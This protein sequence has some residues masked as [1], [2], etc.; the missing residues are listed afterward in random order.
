M[1]GSIRKRGKSYT[2]T[3]DIGRHADG[4]RRQHTETFRTRR[5]ADAALANLLKQAQN[6]SYIKP[7]RLTLSDYLRQW[8]QGREP[9]LR[10]QSIQ[11]YR[12]E[13]ERHLIPSIGTVLLSNLKP[14]D[15]QKMHRDAL[16]AGLSPRS[17]GFIHRLLSQALN[18]AERWGLVDRNV[19]RLAPP[20]K[21]A[22]TEAKFLTAE[23]AARL[24]EAARATP[25]YAVIALGLAT[26]LR[27][28]E[29]LGL[30]WG[31]IEFE[32][33]TLHVVR[34]LA[35]VPNG[36]TRA[37]QVKTESS[38]RI[39]A[40]SPNAV[41][42][43]RAHREQVEAV[44]AKAGGQLK[45]KDFVFSHPTGKPFPPDTVSKAFRR[46]AKAAGIDDARL[47]SL[48]HSHASILLNAGANLKDV[49][50]RLGHSSIAIT[51]DIYAH[52]SAERQAEIAA[53]FDEALS[54][55]A[56]SREQSVSIDGSP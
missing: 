3:I 49:S 35:H 9:H 41:L 55:P 8:L 26:G 20:P 17:T 42:L 21:V 40:L 24:V 25:Y 12:I 29:L 39:V 30:Q 15:I 4:R 45:A 33:S 37:Q 47:H 36:Q 11:R 14:T 10:P 19:A 7:S 23:E 2:L 53:R 5:E 43:L 50:T 22:R 18:H 52:P 56:L 44:Q 32:R 48:R 16:D 6:G 1:K 27:R 51:A 46:I 31:D 28:G 34:S 13:I 38:R 54:V